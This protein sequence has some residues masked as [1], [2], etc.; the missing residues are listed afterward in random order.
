MTEFVKGP[1]LQEP[2]GET[3]PKR[4]PGRPRRDGSAPGTPRSAPL[5]AVNIQES[6]AGILMTINLTFM[7]AGGFGVPLDRDAFDDVEIHALS[8]AIADQCKA[9]PAFKRYVLA[10][11]GV[12]G[13]AGLFGVIA[14]V[15]MRRAARH[16]ML[17]AEADYQGGVLLAQAMHMA[18][19]APSF[20]P[21]PNFAGTPTPVENAA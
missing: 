11:I 14:I 21:P 12:T 20:T 19:P 2:L 9:S 6:V 3:P 15:A 5:P 8:T 18:P 16:G 4:G 10:A 7:V 17:P 13:G 1:P